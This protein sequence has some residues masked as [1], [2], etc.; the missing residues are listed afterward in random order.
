MRARIIH[1]NDQN[2]YYLEER[3]LAASSIGTAHLGHQAPSHQFKARTLKSQ[4]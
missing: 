3:N 1:I 4:W 2:G